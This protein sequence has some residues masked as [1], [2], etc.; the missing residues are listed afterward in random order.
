MAALTWHIQERN[1]YINRHQNKQEQIQTRQ[2]R[3]NIII[4]N[5]KQQQHIQE[6]IYNKQKQ[7]KTK[8]I[9]LYMNNKPTNYYSH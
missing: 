5:T 6:N 1:I 4:R 7:N 9:V 2:L 3:I 8:Q